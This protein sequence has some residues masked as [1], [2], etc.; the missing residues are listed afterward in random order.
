MLGLKP[1]HELDS[2]TRRELDSNT[3]SSSRPG[4][5]PDRARVPVVD[6]NTVEHNVLASDQT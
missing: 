1:G 5:R 6:V 3:E 2:G 4:N